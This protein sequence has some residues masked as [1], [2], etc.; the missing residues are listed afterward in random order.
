MHLTYSDGS[1]SVSIT[2]SMGI[3]LAGRSETSFQE[4]YARADKELYEVK[5]TGKGTW[6]IKE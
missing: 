3:I 4:L 5:R 6:H 1:Q 2:A